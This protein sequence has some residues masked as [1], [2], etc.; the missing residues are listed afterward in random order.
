MGRPRTLRLQLSGGSM[1]R[2]PP[3]CTLSCWRA[4]ARP[5]HLTACL[6]WHTQSVSFSKAGLGGLGFSI[7]WQGCSKAKPLGFR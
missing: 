4:H 3:T 5:Q 6:Y 2:N 1:L 7:S